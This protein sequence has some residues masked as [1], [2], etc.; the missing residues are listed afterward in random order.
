MPADLIPG[1]A[2]LPG[3]QLA[4][5]SLCPQVVKRYIIFLMSLVYIRA[6]IPFTRALLLLLNNLPKA[7]PPNTVT[8]GIGASTCECEF[9]RHTNIQSLG[10]FESTLPSA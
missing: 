2:S 9:W 10:A 3:L 4:A 8:L 6:L 5:F 7:L 1:E